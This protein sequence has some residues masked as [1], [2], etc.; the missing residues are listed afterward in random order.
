MLWDA[1]RARPECDVARCFGWQLAEKPETEDKYGKNRS[2]TAETARSGSLRTRWSGGAV[3]DSKRACRDW[4]ELENR[5]NHPEVVQ[6]MAGGENRLGP[7]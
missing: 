1:F 6:D 3:G 2:V 4:I 5:R 7:I